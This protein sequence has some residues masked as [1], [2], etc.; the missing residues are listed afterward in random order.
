MKVHW[1]SHVF[2]YPL[3]SCKKDLLAIL[4]YIMYNNATKYSRHIREYKQLDGIVLT[5]L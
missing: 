3:L 4:E 1:F 2:K 5:A